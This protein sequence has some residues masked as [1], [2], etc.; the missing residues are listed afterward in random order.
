MFK[1]LS[2]SGNI[3]RQHPASTKKMQKGDDT[4]ATRKLVL[5]WI[6]DTVNKTIQLPP[7]KVDH[8]PRS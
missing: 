7:H 2:S 6:L 8:L 5:G 4:W 1:S 3:H